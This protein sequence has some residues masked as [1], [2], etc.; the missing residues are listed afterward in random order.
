MRRLRF[1]Y[2]F[3]SSSPLGK[4]EKFC[5]VFPFLPRVVHILL[6]KLWEK[7]LQNVENYVIV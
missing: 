5:R 1:V 4:T 2:L 3:L 7:P 6:E